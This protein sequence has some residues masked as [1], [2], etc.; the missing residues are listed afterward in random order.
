M[1]PE[2][3]TKTITARQ[4]FDSTDHTGPVDFGHGRFSYAAMVNGRYLM[5]PN[6]RRRRLFKTAEAAQ[7]ACGDEVL[8][9]LSKARDEK[10]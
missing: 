10:A 7:R 2:I 3:H 5:T 4:A 6:G 8:L 9:N 1:P